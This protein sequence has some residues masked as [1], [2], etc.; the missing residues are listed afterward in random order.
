MAVVITVIGG[1]AVTGTQQSQ[2][3]AIATLMNV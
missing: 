3:K 1:I 2:P